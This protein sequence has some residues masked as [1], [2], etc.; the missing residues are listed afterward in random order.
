MVPHILLCH[1]YFRNSRYPLIAFHPNANVRR[2]ICHFIDS[3]LSFGHSTRFNVN[4]TTP[5]AIGAGGGVPQCIPQSCC[6]GRRAA[7]FASHS[8]LLA[9]HHSKPIRFASFVMRAS[10]WGTC[11][12]H[13]C[14]GLF[15]GAI[16]SASTALCVY[17]MYCTRSTCMLPAQRTDV[18]IRPH[19][20][21]HDIS[22][23]V[24]IYRY[25]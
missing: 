24:Y 18:H 9:L 15:A 12:I 11:R 4:T 5:L 3:L 22:F 25:Y 6:A 7:L 10:G 20:L 19:R 17:V 16:V 1:V 2:T 8:Y 21:V 14:A 13:A 23:I